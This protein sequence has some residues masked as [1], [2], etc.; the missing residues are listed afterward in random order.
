MK[1]MYIGLPTHK[2]KE[3]SIGGIEAMKHESMGRGRKQ[4]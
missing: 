3:I 4:P 1:P 2:I